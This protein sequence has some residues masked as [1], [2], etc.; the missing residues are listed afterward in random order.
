MLNFTR[1]IVQLLAIAL[2]VS[3][4]SLFAQSDRGTITGVVTDQSGAVMSG[5]TV[6]ATNTATGISNPAKTGAGGT[7][8]ILQLHV[9]PYQVVAEFRGFKKFIQSGIVLEIGQTVGLDIH[10]EVGA[11]NETVQVTAQPL[12]DKDT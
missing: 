8:T 5:V 12:M 4:G 10:M 2:L 6:T 11:V 9:G 1:R 7:Y 3:A